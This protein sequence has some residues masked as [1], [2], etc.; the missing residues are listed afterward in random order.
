MLDGCI[1]YNLIKLDAKY[2][3]NA[4][5]GT[6][7]GVY[8]VVS[9]AIQRLQNPKWVNDPQEGLSEAILCVYIVRRNNYGFKELWFETIEIRC[10]LSY[11]F[12]CSS[13]V[14]R[15]SYWIIYNTNSW[16]S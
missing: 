4:F 2:Y 1:G 13:P 3:Y 10:R 12:A 11:V 6:T 8:Y 5:S 7:L 15:D 14:S 9:T 16:G